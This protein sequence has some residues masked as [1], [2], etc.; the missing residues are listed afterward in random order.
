MTEIE[1]VLQTYTLEEILEL[2]ELTD[3]DVLLILVE[4][5]IIT[6]PDP[7]PLDLEND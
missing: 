2:N 4:Q 5:N 7:K 3:E 1:A 6:L